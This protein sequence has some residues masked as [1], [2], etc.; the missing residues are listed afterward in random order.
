MNLLSLHAIENF[1]GWEGI[2]LRMFILQQRKSQPSL[3]RD[4]D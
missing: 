2:S 1:P 3:I 4:T